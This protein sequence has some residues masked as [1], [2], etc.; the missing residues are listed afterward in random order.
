MYQ[1][2][3]FFKILLVQMPLNPVQNVWI[4]HAPRFTP[5]KTIVAPLPLSTFGIPMGARRGG[6]GKSRRLPHPL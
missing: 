4:H 1:I 6:G 3:L 5:I 2:A